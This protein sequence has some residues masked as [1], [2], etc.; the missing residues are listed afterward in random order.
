MKL[1][2]LYKNVYEFN[3]NFN[4]NSSHLFV[5]EATIFLPVHYVQ[6]KKKLINK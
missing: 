3:N 6:N 5:T 2:I 1:Y 4:I